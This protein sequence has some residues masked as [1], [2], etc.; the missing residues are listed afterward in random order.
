MRLI[1]LKYNIDLNINQ[2]EKYDLN[3]KAVSEKI[4]IFKSFLGLQKKDI[5]FTRKHRWEI[6]LNTVSL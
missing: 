3:M 1:L 6:S 4:C 5:A 2:D